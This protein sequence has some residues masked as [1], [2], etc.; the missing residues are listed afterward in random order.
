MVKELVW[1]RIPELNS[2]KFK[3]FSEDCDMLSHY[4]FQSMDI[5]I[6]GGS[7]EDYS[8]FSSDIVI[9]NGLASKNESGE[10]FCIP[11]S[12]N[13]EPNKY[14]LVYEFSKTDNM[15]Y[16]LICMGCLIV[17]KYHFGNDFYVRCEGEANEWKEAVLLASAIL[18][19][20]IEYLIEELFNAP[21]EDLIKTYQ[22]KKEAE[23]KKSL[24]GKPERHSIDTADVAK[25]VRKDLKEHFPKVKFSVRIE[26]YAGGSSI[27]VSW[28]NGPSEKK[29]E[30]IAGHYKAGHFDGSID[31][32]EYN[33]SPYCNSY[34]FFRREL[35]HDLYV[36]EAR[37]IAKEWGCILP[38]D[39]TYYNI[40]S[41][42]WTASRTIS[43]DLERE[44][45]SEVSS[46]D[47]YIEA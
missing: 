9:F 3:M 18:G 10:T 42:L 11:L 39:T 41:A 19:G 29:V 32:Y 24:E 2:E 23:K 40:S 12:R 5:N 25:L 16:G 1:L 13:I 17:A 4:A 15:P 43:A 46:T 14:G 35:D 45:W 33:D 28:K 8:N 26:R 7:G 34:I 38:D 22:A 47:Y 6:A 30:E 31:L 27:N 36:N 44:V 37:R 21:S 20:N